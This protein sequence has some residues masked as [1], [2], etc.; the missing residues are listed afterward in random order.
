MF[1]QLLQKKKKEMKELHEGNEDL[2]VQTDENA[3]PYNKESQ[4]FNNLDINPL[5]NKKL[6]TWNQFQ[7]PN[8]TIEEEKDFDTLQR[9]DVEEI[10]L[11]SLSPIPSCTASQHDHEELTS[12][13]TGYNSEICR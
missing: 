8:S 6:L 1:S 12:F 13:D 10:I 5:P 4:S 7:L 2:V 9:N 3:S 11:P